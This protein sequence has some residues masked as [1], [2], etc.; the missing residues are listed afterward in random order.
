MSTIS[1]QTRKFADL[2]ELSN[3]D[4]NDMLIIHDGNG[5]KKVTAENL[6]RDLSEFLYTPGAGTHNAIYRGNISVHPKQMSNTPPLTVVH[7][8]IC[9]SEITG[10]SVV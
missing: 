3:V 8:M 4:N 1:I 10:Q 7:S 5:V 6:K 9:T 2:E